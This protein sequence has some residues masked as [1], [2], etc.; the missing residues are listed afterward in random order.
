MAEYFGATVADI[1]NTM[2]KRFKPE[3]AKD[4]DILIG[5]EATGEGGGMWTA[6]I[7][8]GTLTVSKVEELKGCKT[9][10]HASAETFVGVT[11]GKIP[12]I[13]ALTNQKLRVVGDPRLLMTLLPKVFVPFTVPPKKKV[14]TARDILATTES[15][16]RPDKAEGLSMNIGY[17]LT[18]ESGGQWTLQIKDGQCKVREGFPDDLT[19]KLIMEAGVYTGMMLGTIDPTAA[20]TSGQVRI[21]GD[22]MAAAATGK[23]FN[24]Y[25]DPHAKEAEELICLQVTN[26]IEQRFASGP[27]TGKWYAGLRE[28][29]F[30]ANVCPKCERTQIPPREIC[31]I[32]RVRVTEYVEL[33]PA[34]TVTNY[35][36]VHFA[37]PDPLTGTVRDTPYAPVYVV[38]DG[39]TES[40]AFAFELKKEDL[41]R[42]RV[43]MR[44]RPV[45]AEKPTGSFKDLICFE[46]E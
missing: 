30:L 25:V 16:F 38:L 1:F 9:T 31:A 22:M 29:K 44:V 32:C 36:V 17:D 45:W 21:E 12:A 35:D 40:E 13:D 15:R 8:H 42:V 34:G 20:F 46:L 3:E 5:Y 18:G 10:V 2:P 37:S 28:K 23:L 7:K 11:L 26:S 43:G 24:K 27:V 4:V 39:A 19:V 14:I 41:N 6:H 33:G